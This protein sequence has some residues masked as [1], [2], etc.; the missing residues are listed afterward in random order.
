MSIVLRAALSSLDRCLKMSHAENMTAYMTCSS[1]MGRDID[2]QLI[3]VPG[4]SLRQDAVKNL[5][6]AVIMYYHSSVVFQIW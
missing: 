5:A 3:L 6:H 1:A 4:S 2:G